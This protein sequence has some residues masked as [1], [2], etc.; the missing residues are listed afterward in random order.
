MNNIKAFAHQLVSAH[1]RRWA[2]NNDPQTTLAQLAYASRTVE[3]ALVACGECKV[4]DLKIA[5]EAELFNGHELKP[6]IEEQ[7]FERRETLDQAV[8]RILQ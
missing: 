1:I 2:R 8:N 5:I 3:D 4:D 7:L 6:E